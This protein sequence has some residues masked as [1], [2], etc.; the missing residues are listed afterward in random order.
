[1]ACESKFYVGSEGKSSDEKTVVTA[2]K[3]GNKHEIKD[4]LEKLQAECRAFNLMNKSS[5][6]HNAKVLGLFHHYFDIAAYCE[7]FVITSIR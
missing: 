3:S 4:R 6:H 7:Y 2:D 5:S 1:M